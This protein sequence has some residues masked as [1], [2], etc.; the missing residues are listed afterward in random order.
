MET[1]NELLAQDNF[2]ELV[3]P[4]RPYPLFS[5][6][7]NHEADG[8]EIDVF[9]EGDGYA[10]SNRTTVSNNPTPIDPV[11]LRLMV[12][13]ENRAIYLA[14]P[15][16]Y[17]WGAYCKQPLWSDDRFSTEVIQSYVSALD[18]IK[19]K[20]GAA[21]FRLHGYSGGGYIALVLSA[22]RNDIS[23]VTTYAGLLNPELWTRYH[24]VAPL[25]LPYESQWLLRESSAVSFIHYCGTKDTVIPCALSEDFIGNSQNHTL[26]SVNA[27]HNNIHDKI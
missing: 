22:L 5:V 15:C 2:L 16:Q 13:A 18:M 26:I 3:Y 20:T 19:L 23:V 9:I 8:R 21:S 24:R 10:W 27:D 1:K 25:N 6:E 4:S 11:A 14:R 7:N 17:V 12:K